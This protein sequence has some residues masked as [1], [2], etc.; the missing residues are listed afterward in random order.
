MAKLYN[1]CKEKKK[2]FEIVFVS[3]DRNEDAFKEYFEE[4]PWSA[5]SF[6]ERTLKTNLS[7]LYE[8]QGIPSLVLL[9]GQGD[10]ITKEGRAA[11]GAGV[12]AFP[13]NQK[14]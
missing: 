7:E 4:M 13:W 14:D 8:V 2:K 5:L 9:T 6:Q 3:S 12:D 11:I 10:L 1:E